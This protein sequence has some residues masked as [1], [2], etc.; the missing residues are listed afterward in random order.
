MIKISSIDQ[1]RPGEVNDRD[2]RRVFMGHSTF[3]LDPVFSYFLG[4]CFSSF[5]HSI[6]SPVISSKT[7]HPNNT[8]PDSPS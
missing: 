5:F 2:N 4:D 3:V 8:S 7:I 1:N 6:R